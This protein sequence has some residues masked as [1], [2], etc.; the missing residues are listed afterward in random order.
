MK[1]GDRVKINIPG[2]PFHGLTGEIIRK[3]TTRDWPAGFNV[4]II[5]ID[6][7]LT[8]RPIGVDEAELELINTP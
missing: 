5:T 7:A 2:H 8:F 3:D 1:P 6:G 4:W